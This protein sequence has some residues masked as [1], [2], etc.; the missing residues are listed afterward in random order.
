MLLLLVLA[1][2]AVLKVPSPNLDRQLLL[3]RKATS[4]IKKAER[5]KGDESVHRMV[6]RKKAEFLDGK[7]HVI[8]HMV[9][10]KL[11]ARNRIGRIGG[12]RASAKKSHSFPYRH[13]DH[14]A[15][16]CL[17]SDNMR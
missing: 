13:S 2:P 8:R 17:Q 1:V 9:L 16:C 7:Q 6:V 12:K 3:A 14:K 15:H 11:W 10:S 4:R 5:D